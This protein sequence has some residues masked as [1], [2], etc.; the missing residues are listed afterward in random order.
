MGV[1]EKVALF[2]IMLFVIIFLP[3]LKKRSRVCY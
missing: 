2:V 3:I 1:E